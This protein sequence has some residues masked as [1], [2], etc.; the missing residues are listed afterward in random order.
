[1]DFLKLSLFAWLSIACLNLGKKKKNCYIG[2]TR[3]TL[4]LG[5]TLHFFFLTKK[6]KRQKNARPILK[7]AKPVSFFQKM[8]ILGFETWSVA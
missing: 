3:P 4:K 2:L 7:K 6:K 5:P 1:M 8:L